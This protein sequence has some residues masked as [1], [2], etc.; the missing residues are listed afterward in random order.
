MEGED[1]AFWTW[2]DLPSVRWA[3]QMGSPSLPITSFSH[4]YPGA[5][6]MLFVLWTEEG[7]CLKSN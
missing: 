7:C 6:F 4:S 1:P 2:D 3:A 5:L